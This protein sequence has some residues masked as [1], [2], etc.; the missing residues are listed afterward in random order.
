MKRRHVLMG[1]AA[2]AVSSNDARSQQPERVWRIGY[3]NFG[4]ENERSASLLDTF[5]ATLKR[6]GWSEGHNI[7]LIIR[8]AGSDTDK[9]QTAAKEVVG[10]HPDLII[11][12][13]TPLVLALQS[14]KSSIPIVFMF[15][16]DPIGSGIV[17][18][19]AHPGGSITGFTAFEPSMGGKWLQIL[20][21]IVPSVNR[22]GLLFNIA[23]APNASLFIHEIEPV[24][25]S[26]SIELSKIPVHD[27]PE[28]EA[29]LRTFASAE[30]R[31]LVVIP[32]IFTTANR[33]QIIALVA[34]LR[35]PTIYSYPFF[36]TEGGL[37][38]YGIP[39]QVQ[40]SQAATYVDRILRGANPGDLPIQQ[41]TKFELAINLKT[42]KAL[43]LTIP[44]ML[45][46]SA[47]EVIE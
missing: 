15:V 27:V 16:S 32:D 36:V 31:A 17:R 34:E 41:P 4:L 23:T 13:G 21:E 10:L 20:R 26:M 11:A 28:M 40:Y 38:S 25:S 22:T 3:L 2:T 6:L 14:E 12:L 18:D 43:G 44:L 29:A 35:L 39:N 8:W 33:K 45:L 9:I 1:L 5:R 37:V 19:L 47:D 30:N 7:E 42:A 24:A 46:A